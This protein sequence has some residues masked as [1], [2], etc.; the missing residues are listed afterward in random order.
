[1]TYYM[2]LKIL[3]GSKVRDNF[4]KK[5]IRF[6]DIVTKGGRV[7]SEITMSLNMTFFLEVVPF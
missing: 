3:L 5:N 4:K 1:M 2:A 7:Q 6:S